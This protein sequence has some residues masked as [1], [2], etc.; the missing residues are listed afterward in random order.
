M[1]KENYI[2]KYNSTMSEIIGL[3]SNIKIKVNLA[4]QY[5]ANHGDSF[6]DWS[7]LADF[8]HKLTF[9]KIISP[10]HARNILKT[11]NPNLI[12]SIEKHTIK[13]ASN[14]SKDDTRILDSV[15]SDEL[16]GNTKKEMKKVFDEDTLKTSLFNL[17]KKA[18]NNGFAIEKIKAVFDSAIG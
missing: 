16:A 3:H 12:Y 5:A 18:K 17:I 11:T 2:E 1:P 8:I 6:G 13:Q 14:F 15:W 4:Y 10:L 9:E 7:L